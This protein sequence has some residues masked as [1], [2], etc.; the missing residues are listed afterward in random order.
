VSLLQFEPFGPPGLFNDA[1]AKR[2]C[3]PAHIPLHY[4]LFVPIHHSSI[5]SAFIIWGFPIMFPSHLFH[6]LLRRVPDQDLMLSSFSLVCF[7]QRDTCCCIL[8]LYR[9]AELSCLLN[10]LTTLI[11]FIPALFR[12]MF[13]QPHG[14][15]TH[16]HSSRS[17]PSSRVSVS[18]P[19]RHVHACT[20]LQER[21]ET[22]TVQLFQYIQAPSRFS[23]IDGNVNFIPSL[24]HGFLSPSNSLPSL[25][26]GRG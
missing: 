5:L 11:Y 2:V 10:L 3:I 15:S 7:C 13:T 25:D 16:S 19:T 20:Q 12:H 1:D 24:P 18:L 23:P 21:Q 17:F 26:A 4:I 8:F 22:F 9:I 14:T 6:F